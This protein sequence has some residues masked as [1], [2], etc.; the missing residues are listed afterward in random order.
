MDG[1]SMA[2]PKKVKY[3]VGDFETTV[4]EGQKNTEVWASAIVEMF[5]E[6]VSIFHS[7]DE[8]WEYLSGLKSNLIVYFHNLKFDGNFWISFFLNKLHLKQAYTGDG[9][10]SCE[11]KHDKEMYNSTFKYTISEI[12]Q[13][14]SIKVKIN[15]KVIEFRDS[16]KLLPFSVKEIE[17]AFKTKHQK[18][19]ME[20]TG[21]RYAGCE[22]KPK[23]KKYI[24]ND[25]LVVKEALEI[26]FQAGHNRLTIG[27][28]CLA[29]Y[30][31]IVGE[32]DWKRRFPDVS[33]I[34]LDSEIYGKPTVDAYIRKSYR[35]GWCYLVKGKEN[36]IYTNGTTADVNSL[37]PSMM[38]SM[39]GNRYPVGKPM[40]WSGNFIPDRALQNNMYFFIRIKTK[41]YLR[42]GKL[43]FIQIKGNMLYKGTES[44]QTSDVFDKATGKYYD[45][46]ID[47]DGNTC[48][49]RVEL[50]LTMTDYFLILEH[51]EL[52][53]FE[54][55]DGCFFYS[56][57]GI[58][59]EYIDK[60]AKIKM[61]SKGARRTLA[62]LFLNN[63]YGKMASS[64]DSS[65]KLAYVK[66]DNSIGFINITAKDKEAGYIP[67][68]SAITS[69]A[70]NFT[71]R[72]AQANY[73]GVE[74]HGFIYAD[75]DSIH[76]DLPPE[77]ITGI[78]VHET[79]F[80]AWKL[81]SCWDRAIFARQKTYI[82]HVTHEDLQKIEEPY[83]NIKCAGM[84]Q[85]CKD[86]FELSMTGKAVYDEYKENTPI[87][88]FLF[89]QVTHEAIVRTFDDFK[90][91]LNVPCKLIPKR[92][93]GGV[94][95]VESTYQMR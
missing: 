6:D 81:E 76:C 60:Y 88:R 43:P 78:K 77:Q 24:A 41:F 42:S 92:I 47:I 93:D 95:L 50:T 57:I 17:K 12:G 34:E 91:G 79:D 30:K 73:H 74:E 25:V 3:L 58:F 33:Q 56:E 71:I 7:I 11:W 29:E 83:N 32:D 14:Y 53:D 22:I 72:A 16:L 2:R 80:C 27:S 1:D 44:L 94:L 89:N 38:H 67:V 8:T 69:Y 66:D 86:L 13:W 46:Y 20:Y 48:D 85:R 35:G 82:E 19:D 15:N 51:Y 21:F 49:T 84:P 52:V 62:K 5:T 61:T 90:I 64:T 36:K 63:L 55:L 68:G 26:V 31:Q 59:D 75:T 40:F 23:E 65:F 9:V 18:L 4:Y 45:K 37:Y 87:N 39:S 54:I 28:C 10:N 70:R